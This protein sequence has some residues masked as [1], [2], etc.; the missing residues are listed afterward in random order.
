MPSIRV[1]TSGWSYQDWIGPFYPP[2]TPAC[3]FLSWYA[4]RFNTVEVDSTFY[5]IPPAGRTATWAASTPGDFRFCL[6][7]PQVITHEKALV[8]CDEDRDAFLRAI[9]PLGAKAYALLLQFGYFNKRAFRHAHEFFDRLDNFLQKYPGPVPLAV[10]IRNRLWLTPEFFRLLQSHRAAYC[11]ADHAWMPSPEEVLA[12]HDVLTG[13]SLYVRLIGD[14]AGIE[15]VTRTWDRVVVDR[16]EAIRRLVA[17]LAGIVPRS[18]IVVFI[19]NHYAG[20]APASCEDL[21]A[22][23]ARANADR[24]W[25]IPE[26]F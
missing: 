9:E 3:D 22:A 16:T 12:R 10:E 6:K 17:A 18:D 20:H 1:G 25:E 26:G 24:R 19:N 5:A 13:A 23:L 14:R 8:D 21:L 2:G 7:V 11:L 4:D 15:K